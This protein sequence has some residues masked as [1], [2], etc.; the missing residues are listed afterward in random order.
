VATR[1]ERWLLDTNVWIFG[2]RGD[3]LFTACAQI[4]D[5]I[6]SFAAIV[7]RQ[8]LK[9][10]NVNFS[11]TEARKFYQLANE[12]PKHIELSWESARPKE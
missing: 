8:V 2:L 6:G 7:L 5:L 12:H 10:L 4:L 1:T 9:E 3:T 11:Q